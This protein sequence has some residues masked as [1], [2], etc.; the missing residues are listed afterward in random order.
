[1]ITGIHVFLYYI[2]YVWF[3]LDNNYKKQIQYVLLRERCNF[4]YFLFANFV[5][6]VCVGIYV[7]CNISLC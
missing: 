5:C 4:K 7:E 1:M 3:Y 6:T 2:F